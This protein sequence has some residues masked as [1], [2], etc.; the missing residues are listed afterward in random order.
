VA[1]PKFYI[2]EHSKKDKITEELTLHHNTNQP[3][4]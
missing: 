4:E 1:F 2:N 3:I